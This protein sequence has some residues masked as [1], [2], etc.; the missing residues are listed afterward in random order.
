VD[1]VVQMRDQG[2]L[3]EFVTDTRRKCAQDDEN[4]DPDTIRAEAR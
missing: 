4:P 2:K 3:D 1:K